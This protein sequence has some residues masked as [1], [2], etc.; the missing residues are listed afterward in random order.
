MVMTTLLKGP[1][2]EVRVYVDTYLDADGDEHDGYFFDVEHSAECDHEND[3]CILD[4]D[5]WPPEAHEIPGV[6]QQGVRY[7][8]PL[9]ETEDSYLEWR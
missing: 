5:F 1:W 7:V 8:I 4:L 6:G 2:H 3:N 9:S